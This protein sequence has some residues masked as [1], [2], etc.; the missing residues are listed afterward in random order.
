MIAKGSWGNNGAGGVVHRFHKRESCV[1]HSVHRFP[2]SSTIIRFRG[3]QAQ[4]RHAEQRAKWPR[5]NMPAL[6]ALAVSAKHPLALTLWKAPAYNRRALPQNQRGASRRKC[7]KNLPAECTEACEDAWLPSPHGHSRRSRDSR[8]PPSQGAQG[9]ERVGTRLS[10]GVLHGRDRMSTIKSTR[11]IDTIFRTATRVAHPTLIAL[12][13]RTP[14]GRGRSGRVA[15]IAG[16]KLGGA[17]LRNRS[18]RVLREAARR[19]GAPWPGQDVALIARSETAKATVAEL[20]AAL[21][22]ILSRAGL[23]R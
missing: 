11:E 4:A 17:V 15:F 6:P 16:K 20:D 2:T 7:E 8:R 12:I 23:D 3:L 21:S 14:E 9:P 13:A 1:F 10:A 19:A 18:R 22:S 5:R